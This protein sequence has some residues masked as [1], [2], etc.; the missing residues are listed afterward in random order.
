MKAAAQSRQ[1]TSDRSGSP[2]PTGALPA[3]L[4]DGHAHVFAPDLAFITP[5]RYTP[6]YAATVDQFIAH[7]DACGLQGGLLTQPSFLGTDNTHML[8]AV[9]RHPDRLRAVVVVEP[10]ID[11][12]DLD[13]LARRG[14]VGIRL[15]LE[16]RDLP[17][18][19]SDPWPGLFERLRRRNWHVEL[20]RK[21]RDLPRLLAPLLHAGVRI[22]VDHFGRPDPELGA[23]DPGF[24]ALL[25]SAARGRVWVKVSAAYRT[26]DVERGAQLAPMLL[27]R[28]LGAFEVNRL[29]WASDWPHTQFESRVDYRDCFDALARWSSDPRQVDRLRSEGL[30]ALLDRVV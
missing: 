2:D 13:S 22:C 25:D 15:N 23:D 12:R 18:L 3:G 29:I 8:D 27:S 1:A 19:S 20:H 26:G 14:A 21:A 11:D 4:Y 16:G 28:L 7:L 10:T 9:A 24:I 5:R 6:D 30:S 17:D